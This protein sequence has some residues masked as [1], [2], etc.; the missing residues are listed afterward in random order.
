M[1]ISYVKTVRCWGVSLLPK[2]NPPEVGSGEQPAKPTSSEHLPPEG[3]K[4]SEDDA[5]AAFREGGKPGGAVLTAIYLRDSPNWLLNGPYLTKHYGRGKELTTHIK[6]GRAKAYIY[7]ELLVLR[8]RK[9]ANE[10]D[11]EERR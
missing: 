4:F 9:G 11:R 8:D 6:V 3:T 2:G 5:P 1:A 7:T 10:V